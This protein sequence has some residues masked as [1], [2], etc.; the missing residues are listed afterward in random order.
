MRS[1][2]DTLPDDPDI[3]PPQYEA[4]HWDDTKAAIARIQTRTLAKI[5]AGGELESNRGKPWHL[6]L[7]IFNAIFTGLNLSA[8]HVGVAA[9]TGVISLY[10]FAL[11][12]LSYRKPPKPDPLDQMA[13][14]EEAEAEVD[15]LLES[16]YEV[17]HNRALPP[18]P[19]AAEVRESESR[20]AGWG[21]GS[22]P[23]VMHMS[24]VT[25]EPV[26]RIEFGSEPPMNV[27]TVR[28]PRSHNGAM[29]PFPEAPARAA[30]RIAHLTARAGEM[31]DRA[32]ELRSRDHYFWAFVN[33]KR[34]EH[35][36]HRAARH[37][38][39]TRG[40]QCGIF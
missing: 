4:N 18:G 5:E 16:A 40:G 31:Q 7:G 23:F 1:T 27:A 29:W 10:L 26:G 15:A 34:A 21:A 12:A 28:R 11:W 30:I 6:G 2:S 33:S 22:T 9:V 35:L 38:F 8:G 32:A 19:A 39:R 14:L 17:D 37:E 13:V 20:E 36:Q 25:P 24:A 3:A